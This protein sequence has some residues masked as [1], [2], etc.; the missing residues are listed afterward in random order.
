MLRNAFAD[1]STEDRQEVIEM[2]LTNLLSRTAFLD[3]NGRTRVSIEAGSMATLTTVTTVT[4]VG[5]TA[6]VGGLLANADQYVQ[7]QYPASSLRQRI[8]YTP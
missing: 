8:N 2:L 1:L 3:S 7:M 4:T 6:S 5:N